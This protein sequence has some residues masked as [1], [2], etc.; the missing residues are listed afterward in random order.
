MVWHFWVVCTNLRHLGWKCVPGTN[1][2]AFFWSLSDEEK[3]VN[4][5][6]KGR[7]IGDLGWTQIQIQA[8]RRP[9]SDVSST[10]PVWTG[11]DPV[12]KQD[13]HIVHLETLQWQGALATNLPTPLFLWPLGRKVQD[14]CLDSLP[15]LILGSTYLDPLIYWCLHQRAVWQHFKLNIFVCTTDIWSLKSQALTLIFWIL[16][17]CYVEV[18]YKK[19]IIQK[20][21]LIMS[22]SS[23]I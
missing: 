23:L 11:L 14:Y 22:T 2:L 6:C 8:W 9:R 16:D 10:K 4:K 5:I 21:D 17:S 19:Y 3:K 1:T 12:I 18:S 7:R 13:I 15:Y 20:P